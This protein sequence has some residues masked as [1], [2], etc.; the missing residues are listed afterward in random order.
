MFEKFILLQLAKW[1]EGVKSM[2]RAYDHSVKAEPYTVVGLN[3]KSSG[4]DITREQV[5]RQ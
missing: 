3:Q 5:G 4:E 2:C 1:G